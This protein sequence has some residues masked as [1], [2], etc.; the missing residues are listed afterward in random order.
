MVD[1][2][3]NYANTSD[4]FK[5]FVN[6]EFYGEYAYSDLFIV[7]GPFAGDGS[8][9]TFEIQDANHPDCG[10]HLT[11]EAPNCEVGCQ[12]GDLV[13]DLISD[14]ADGSYFLLDFNHSGT[15]N[16]GFDVFYNNESLGF[17]SYNE[18]PLE[19]FIPCNLG[20]PGVLTVCDND[21]LDCCASIELEL[22]DCVPECDIWDLSATPDCNADGDYF[23]LV[24]FNYVNVGSLGFNMSYA[25][26]NLGTF[27]YAD[28]PILI[29]PYPGDG[30]QNDLIVR[31]N[32]TGQCKEKLE[33]EPILC[34]D[35]CA[36][37]NLTATTSCDPNDDSYDVTIN[38]D[39]VNPGNNFFTVFVDGQ[40]LGSFL[41]ADLPLTIE[42]YEGVPGANIQSL[43]VCINDMPNCCQDVSFEVPDCDAPPCEI[44]NL[45]ITNYE[46]NAEGEIFVQLDFDYGNV[47]TN[48]FKFY[49]QGQYIGLYNYN[50]VPFNYGPIQNNGNNWTFGVRDSQIP[51]CKAV[52]V[53]DPINCDENCDVFDLVVDPGACSPN[54]GYALFINFGYSG[55]TSDIFEV[56]HMGQVVGTYPLS[57]LPI[58]IENFPDPVNPVEGVTVCI[59]GSF[60]CCASVEFQTPE[61]PMALVWPGDANDNNIANNNDLLNIGIAYGSTGP[62]RTNTSINWE[63]MESADWMLQFDGSGADYKH[64][65]TNG[66][67]M[68]NSADVL[69]IL[70]N[71]NETHGPVGI[72]PNEVGGANDPPVYVDLPSP[73]EVVLG[74]PFS[75]PIMIGT[76]TIPAEDFY[77]LAFTIQFD[78]AIIDPNSVSV[79][80][81]PS[82]A[83]APG[84]NLLVLSKTFANQ[85]YIDVALVRNNQEEVTGGGMVASFVGIID[86][87]LGKTDVEVEIVQVHMIKRN[88]DL[89]PVQLPVETIAIQGP[90]TNY[91]D[92]LAQVNLYPNPSTGKIYLNTPEGLVID[93]WEITDAQSGSYFTG[94]AIN[95]HQIDLSAL[96]TGIYVIRLKTPEGVVVRRVM[97]Q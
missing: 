73:S 5:V 21:N 81:M 41:L 88:E 71:Y 76:E 66:D 30:S 85:G 24:N 53:T 4:F 14:N 54:G 89:I 1:I 56:I 48:G 32:E 96:P 36:I 10:Q 78:P 27:Q 37:F 35:E 46:C 2:N 91:Q 61:C 34:T 70:E 18:L 20:T 97:K 92:R 12:I 7:I 17:Y 72:E 59:P 47:S 68:I 93:Q 52:L 8:V 75:A 38:F 31:D 67:G 94:T 80:F 50:Q 42:N 62:E 19:L 90:N 44:T 26:V 84:L 57:E 65:D 23:L 43:V 64:A 28:L 58:T 40:S 3:F 95:N 33:V 9:Y 74:E 63:G 45:A 77:G 13:L 60:E 49:F 6:N 79:E 16:L 86:D 87:V 22:N 55:A 39:Y 11:I 69:A 51:G 29:G 83:G 25:G 15:S 82:W